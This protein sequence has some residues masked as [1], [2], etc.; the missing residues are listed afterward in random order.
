MSADKYQEISRIE[1]VKEY[2]CQTETKTQKL[3][4]KYVNNIIFIDDV[5]SLDNKKNHEL[6]I[7]Q[8]TPEIL[9]KNILN[10]NI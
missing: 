7:Y 8:K 2:F 5:Y 4:D 9:V 6:S 10:N 1:L 3:I